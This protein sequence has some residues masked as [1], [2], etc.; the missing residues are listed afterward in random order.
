MSPDSLCLCLRP[1]LPRSPP[2]SLSCVMK[3]TEPVSP[4]LALWPLRGRGA[5]ARARARARV[6]SPPLS[7][8]GPRSPPR[9]LPLRLPRRACR[10]RSLSVC[11][12]LVAR[13]SQPATSLTCASP[14]RRGGRVGDARISRG[15]GRREGRS[16][17]AL[18]PPGLGGRAPPPSDGALGALGARSS[19]SSESSEG[20][21]RS[22]ESEL[23][24]QT[25]P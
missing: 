17:A 21:E 3:V 20:S 13:G 10:R 9:S 7:L 2:P 6:V 19:P 23:P 11:R 16:P 22:S 24:G 5:P 4:S 12:V 18:P 8:S 15:R 1:A 14:T 25:L